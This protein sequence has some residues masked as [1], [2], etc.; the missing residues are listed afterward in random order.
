MRR[1]SAVGPQISILLF[2]SLAALVLA[3]DGARAAGALGGASLDAET[4]KTLKRN[5]GLSLSKKKGPYS[6]NF[7]VCQDN[8]KKPVQLPDGRIVSPCGT[9]AKFCAA[10]RTAWA[11]A[12]AKERMYIANIFSRDLHEWD[13]FPDHHDLVR[14]Y[15]LEKFF[16]DT[17]PDHKLAVMRAYGGLSGAEYEA[18]DAPLFAERYLADPSFDNARHHLL[19]YELQRRFFVRDEQGQIQKIRNLASR[20]YA[21]DRKFKPLRDATHNQ[22]SAALLPRLEAYRTKIPS[23]ARKDLDALIA[24]IRKLTSLDES[25]LAPQIKALKDADVR[26]DLTEELP[27]QDATPVQALEALGKIMVTSRQAVAEGEVSPADRR[28]LLNLSVTASA[29]IQRRG[30]DLLASKEPITV[31]ED[32]R[33]LGALTDAAY[34][35]G[36]LTEREW[37]AATANVEGALDEGTQTR[38]ELQ[39][40]VRRAKRVVEWAQTGV[41]L[42]F[43]EVLPAWTFLLPSTAFIADDVLRGS[44]LLLYAGFLDELENFISGTEPVRHELFGTSVSTDVRALN[45]GLAV[46]TLRIDP[47]AGSYSREEIV[48]LPETPPDLQPAA[49]IL[50]QGEGNVVS[51]VQLLARALGIPNVVLGAGQF[52]TLARHDGEDVVLIAT[53]GGRVHVQKSSELSPQEQAVVAEFTKSAERSSDGAL[54]AEAKKLHIDRD[55]LDVT[56]AAPLP[57]SELRRKDSGVRAGPKASFLGELKSL[58]PDNVARGVVVPFGAYYA[59]FQAA[60]VA[61]PAALAGKGIATAGE[62]L[63]DF[64]RQT[65]QTFFD[66]M[67]PAGTPEKELSAWIRPR[68]EVM[69]YSLEQAPLDPKLTAAIRERLDDEGLLDSADPSQTVGCFVRSDTN[70][71]DLDDF[72]G[73]G[74]NLTLFNLRSL[75]EVYDGIKEVWASPFSYRSFSWRQTLIDEPMWVLPSIVILESI[76]SEKSG[77]LVTADIETGDPNKM[78]IATSEGVGGAV[79]G[80]PAETLLWSSDGVELITMFKSPYRRLLQPGGGSKVVPS[81][82]NAYVLSE[83]EL[84]DLVE[85]AEEIRDELEPARDPAGRPMPWDIEFGFADGHLWL[86]QTRP[87]V[88]NEELANMPAL[89]ALDGKKPGAGDSISLEEN[90]R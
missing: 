70:V 20:I 56:S 29:V 47:A 68:L 7:C 10:Y 25:V 54:G 71:E 87:F 78:L 57:L 79:D 30:S 18:R 40:V 50:T 13:T 28:R 75:D 14:G 36:L 48:A 4:Q 88:G 5:F 27:P 11:E 41:V 73:A 33:I 84:D 19:A 53:P 62:P 66:E 31:G 26:D 23:G 35:A 15:I 77:V 38:A 8:A 65:Y 82:G 44:P 2:L 63:P 60:K 12:L 43:E 90:V 21:A 89:A 49:G 58:F 69:Q 17:H 64:V 6:P 86:F 3:P 37:K 67:I 61:V 42:A 22:V 74:L 76:P 85:A 32:L 72:N 59:H 81:T 45:P 46:G 1:S 9:T 39:Q 34:G 16:I 52:K 80:T 83:D 51:H 55:R 24:E